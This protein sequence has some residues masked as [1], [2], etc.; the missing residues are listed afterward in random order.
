M[1]GGSVNSIGMA[2]APLMVS[3]FIFYNVSL[4]DVNSSQFLFPVFIIILIM[5]LVTV[6]VSRIKFPDLPENT[7]TQTIPLQK[8]IWSF[9]RVRLGLWALGIYVGIEVA[10]GANINMY[11]VS[12][13]HS[14]ALKATHMAALYWGFLLIGRLIGSFLK[15]VSSQR[16]LLTGAVGAIF[17][18]L[19]TIIFNNPWILTLIGLFHSIMWPAIFT[20]ATDKLGPYT[21]KA[22]GI[23]MIGVI[24]GGII[25]LL[26]GISADILSG[27]WRWT[28]GLIVLGEVYVLFYALSGYKIK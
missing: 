13:G 14:F 22:S 25:P 1:I 12:L 26:Q 5:I 11:A 18:L 27:I 8:S 16:Q 4:S 6:L 21:A 19:L 2:I 23:L 15:N 17:F 28:W 3:H 7:N 9:R 24:G 20:L 10:V